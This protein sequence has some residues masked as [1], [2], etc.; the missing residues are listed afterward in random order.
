MTQEKNVG[1]GGQ[2]ESFDYGHYS[3]MFGAVLKDFFAARSDLYIKQNCAV[4]LYPKE[5]SGCLEGRKII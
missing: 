2:G 1:F 5:T 4:D 3:K